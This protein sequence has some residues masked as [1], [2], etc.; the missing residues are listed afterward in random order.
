ML[1]RP[2]APLLVR[3]A[4]PLTA[5][6]GAA[7]P[8]A[9]AASAP[10]EEVEIHLITI[11]DGE[12]I[13]T[14]G[15]H[16]ALMV[17]GL[18]DGEP[19]PNN[20]LVYNYGDADF[21]DPELALRFLRGEARFRLA[22]IGSLQETVDD[23]GVRQARNVWRQKLNLRPD[24]AEAVAER[25]ATGALPENRDYRYHHS[26]ATCTTKIRDLLDEVTGG[27]VRRSLVDAPAQPETFREVQRVLFRKHHLAAIGGDLIFG[28]S[29]DLPLDKYA[30]VVDPPRM[31]EYL[32]D[33]EVPAPEGGTR[34]LA[35]P[36]VALIEYLGPPVVEMPSIATSVAAILA[37]I[38][39]GAGLG[40]A[41]RKLPQRT[42]G[43]ALW[44]MVYPLFS[45]LVGLLL[46][47]IFLFAGVDELRENDNLLVFPATDLLLVA[48]GARWLRRP[49]RGGELRVLRGYAYLRFAA[50]GVILV[51]HLLGV[52]FQRPW[53]FVV[54]SFSYAGGL[55][56]LARRASV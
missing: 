29:H 30:A 56:K 35:E 21:D 11:G 44:L 31:M 19:D 17:A 54:L 48:L 40:R 33:V 5:L 20:T 3:L 32:Q 50:L 43:A 42:S 28:R 26:K 23:Y 27:A 47:A 7:T 16:T 46:L 39:L 8:G 25:L 45:G 18:R 36:P 10:A 52:L 34:P 55:V 2:R 38:L 6:V 37:M 12:H 4:L 15:G 53:L 49:L 22:V 1:R 14:A 24:E 51:L 9:A 13:L 41:G